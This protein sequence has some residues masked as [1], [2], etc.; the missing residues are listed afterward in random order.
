MPELPEVETVMR[1][2]DEVLT[3]RRI[4]SVNQRRKDLRVPFPKDLKSS[5]EGAL[6]RDMKR[7]AKYIVMNLDN[8][9]SVILHLGMSG[10]IN[11]SEDAD[12][13]QIQKHDHLILILDDGSLMSFNDARRFGMVMISNQNN[14]ESHP[15]F[16][17]LGPEPFDNKFSAP[18]LYDSLKEKKTTFKAALMDQ[19][20]V[21]GLGN[22]YV[23]ESLFYAGIDPQRL[24]RSITKNESELLVKAIRDV[25]QKA[26]EAGGSTLKDFRHADGEL[27]YFQHNFAV[28]DRE[29][30]TCPECNCELNKTGGVKKMTQNGRSTYYCSVKQG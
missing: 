6:I 12:S 23:C 13:Y 22:I 14:I 2:M 21:A 15:S 9:L 10:R 27:G 30:E 25:L 8:D 5:L 28:Y 19:R 26:I 18:V 17:K 4:I 7:R 16:K 1:G 24:C 20:I 29:G 11:L 3:G